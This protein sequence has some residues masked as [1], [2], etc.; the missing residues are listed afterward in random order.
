MAKRYWKVKG[1]MGYAGTESVEEIDA[2]DEFGEEQTEAM[3]DEEVA[4]ELENYMWDE[5]STKIDVF[6]EPDE[7]KNKKS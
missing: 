4:T 6:A 5:L 1:D 7:E 2:H 3:T